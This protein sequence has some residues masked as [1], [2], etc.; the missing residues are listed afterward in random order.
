MKT[1]IV[2]IG[3]SQGVRIPK[4]LLDQTGLQGE[5]EIKAHENSL[6]I[7]ATRKPR[8]GWEEAFRTMAERGDDRLLDPDVPSLTSWDDTEWEW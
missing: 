7:S 8:E 4:P 6:I 5:V 2:R 1:R 3:N